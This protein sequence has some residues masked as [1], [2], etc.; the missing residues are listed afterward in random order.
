MAERNR[1]D[2]KAM[3]NPIWARKKLD[4]KTSKVTLS[5]PR[6]PSQPSRPRNDLIRAFRN[7][8]C[9][10]RLWCFAQQGA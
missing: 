9:R 4:F 5:P 7:G 2:S 1:T 10:R 6:L 8:R 3:E